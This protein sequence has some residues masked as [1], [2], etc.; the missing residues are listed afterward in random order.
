METVQGDEKDV[1]FVSI[2]YGKTSN[3]RLYTN[4]GQINKT[5]GERRLN[6]IMTRAKLRCELFANFSHIDLKELQGSKESPN[7]N[8]DILCKFL[9]Y[10]ATR[11]IKSEPKGQRTFDSPFE[12]QVYKE[13]E[14]MGFKVTPQVYSNGFYVDMAIH[15]PKRS[16]EYV[17]GVECDGAT[18]H[19]SGW[20]KRRDR[21][22][23]NILKENG[24]EIYRI[25]STD[26]FRSQENE[27]KKLKDVIEERIR[28]WHKEGTPKF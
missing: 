7:K 13:I 8:V 19:S 18:Y 25:W 26:W 6:V 15:H 28:Y 16:G 27:I 14:K 11:K 21:I 22:R 24:W 9:E 3:G 12:I 5:G 17:L 20:A 4:F 23:E 2:G 1:I 10:A